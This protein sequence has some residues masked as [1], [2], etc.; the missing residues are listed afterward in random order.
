[1]IKNC[2]SH[3]ARV[4]RLNTRFIL[5]HLKLDKEFIITGHGLIQQKDND[6]NGNNGVAATTAVAGADAGTRSGGG[7]G[8]GMPRG[9]VG[10]NGENKIVNNDPT[11]PNGTQGPT[12]QSA[13]GMN[14]GGLD[15][16]GGENAHGGGGRGCGTGR[17]GG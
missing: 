6:A 10:N 16:N 14:G 13:T 17:G 9:S 1:M 11:T 4:A 3:D 8:G 7:P 15:R 12:G 5:N 2:E